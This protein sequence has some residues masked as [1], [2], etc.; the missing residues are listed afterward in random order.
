MEQ[1]WYLELVSDCVKVC[2]S[3]WK[4]VLV[5]SHAPAKGKLLWLV[6]NAG[7]SQRFP[8]WEGDLISP[9]A[10]CLSEKQKKL[11]FSTE[12]SNHSIMAYMLYWHLELFSNTTNKQL[13]S[14][15]RSSNTD[16]TLTQ[17]LSSTHQEWT[18]VKFLPDLIFFCSRN[19]H[20]CFWYPGLEETGGSWSL[21]YCPLAGSVEFSRNQA[22]GL[23]ETEQWSRHAG[24]SSDQ[25]SK[26]NGRWMWWSAEVRTEWAL[27]GTRLE[28]P[29]PSHKRTQQ[30]LRSWQMRST[31]ETQQNT[32]RIWARNRQC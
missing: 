21:V 7:S 29:V 15:P 3:S 19:K 12:C 27:L 17:I 28:G 26:A 4:K 30:K 25:G 8:D 32:A 18:N 24:R 2:L 16:L 1:S 6:N 9:Y 13:R 11:F 23:D 31:P 20:G 14:W 22:T 10:F 5:G